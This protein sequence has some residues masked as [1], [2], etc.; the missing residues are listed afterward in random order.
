[1]KKK[2]DIKIKKVERRTMIVYNEIINMPWARF[3]NK[4]K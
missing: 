1:M 3:N 2:S 4:I